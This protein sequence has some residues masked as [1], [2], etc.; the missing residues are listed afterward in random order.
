MVL[1]HLVQEREVPADT[2]VQESLQVQDS[3][4]VLVVLRLVKDPKV[5]RADQ[6]VSQVERH[7]DLRTDTLHQ[8]G[9]QGQLSHPHNQE[10]D[11]EDIQ[12]VSLKVPVVDTQV[13]RVQVDLADNN[14]RGRVVGIQVP[15]VDLVEVIL[16]GKV[17]ADKAVDTQVV[18][19]LAPQLEDTQAV[20]LEG[21]QVDRDLVVQ[22]VD[23]VQ[24]DLEDIL[25]GLEVL[26]VLVAS[27]VVM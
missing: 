5:P 24:A 7:Q 18:K 14:L 13:V 20:Q 19:D 11:L 10:A 4:E 16:V 8:V 9:P 2:Q 6:E 21:I 23:K 26:E 12:V 27:L 15:P 22:L 17:L 25:E 3:L 1:E